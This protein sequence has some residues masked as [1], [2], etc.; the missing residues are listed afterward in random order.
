MKNKGQSR[1]MSFIESIAN[2]TIGY[3]V[4]VGAQYAIFPLFDVYIPLE[5][6]LLMGAL[7]TVVS[8]VRSYYVRRLFNWLHFVRGVK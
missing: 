6:H 5:Q 1:K 2:V 4:A 3:A 8:V 7:F